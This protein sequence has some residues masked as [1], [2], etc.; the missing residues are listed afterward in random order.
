MSV[1]VI[2]LL[3]LLGGGIAVL[4]KSQGAEVRS[5]RSFAQDSCVMLDA[6]GRT[7]LVRVVRAL[8][9]ANAAGLRQSYGVPTVPTAD[10]VLATP[11]R[12]QC[13]AAAQSFRQLRGTMLFDSAYPV[14]MVRLASAG[15]IGRSMRG[16]DSGELYAVFDTAFVARAIFGLAR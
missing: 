1:S 14:A 16:T 5:E 10:V 3:A 8:M 6:S 9:S 15:Y 11:T 7:D 12:A 4:P 13:S 2:A